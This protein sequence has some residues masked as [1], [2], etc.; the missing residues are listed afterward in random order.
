[1][2]DLWIVVEM[3]MSWNNGNGIVMESKTEYRG[4][5]LSGVLV[6]A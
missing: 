2:S 4:S 1:M 5:W 6:E 3:S